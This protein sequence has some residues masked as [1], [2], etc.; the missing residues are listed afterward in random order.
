MIENNI[1]ELSYE[2]IFCNKNIDEKKLKHTE[3]YEPCHDDC[4]KRNE[5]FWEERDEVISLVGW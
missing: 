1:V 2:C 3:D 4:L 5:E